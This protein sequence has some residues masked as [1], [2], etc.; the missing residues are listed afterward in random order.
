LADKKDTQ[1]KRTSTKKPRSQWQK[2]VL[3]QR[4]IGI[5]GVSIVLA[6]ILILSSGWFFNQYLPIDRQMNKTALTVG[7]KS[8]ST[9]YFVD[10]LRLY[11]GDYQ[12]GWYAEYLIDET[13]K[14]IERATIIQVAASALGIVVT[15]DDLKQY[16][17]EAGFPNN[18]AVRDYAYT[19]LIVSKLR[20]D[21][22]GPMVP[23]RAEYREVM[24]MLL[25]SKSHADEVR[26]RI[27]AG[28]DFGEIAASLSLES[29]TKEGSGVFGPYPKDLFDHKLSSKGFGDAV[30]Q[31]SVDAWGLYFDD[32]IKKSVGYWLVK[33]TERNEE[34]SK[35]RVSGMLL[36][37]LEEAE[38]IKARLDKGESFSALAE[39][40]SQSWSDE[41][42][43]DL[44]WIKPGDS[45]A[46]ASYV[47]N[48]QT[49]I[50]AVSDPIKD[51]GKS[52][53]GGY[54]LYKVVSISPDKFISADDRSDLITKMIED[55][56]DEQKSS[57]DN[58][59]LVSYLDDDR[60]A[61]IVKRIEGN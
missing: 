5:S 2:E 60:R 13:E 44:S 26:A 34:E 11:C 58:F 18:D 3:R 29:K 54:W 48:D 8:Y 4:I 45:H 50:G 51:T 30:F 14:S 57:G 1:L 55:W 16:M 35:V 19:Q 46:Y 24:A 22:F 20:N 56:V 15:D 37:S 12:Y 43:D 17:K 28:E 38:E 59:I 7:N 21:Y 47:L 41:D 32:S 31:Q 49:K 10:L 40:Y 52:T 23:A 6:V 9:A 39:K 25:E 27:N 53:E 42:K 33:V 61:F 36:S